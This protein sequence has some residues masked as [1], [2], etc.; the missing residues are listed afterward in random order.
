MINHSPRRLLCLDLKRGIARRYLD[1]KRVEN[2]TVQCGDE[3]TPEFRR[4]LEAFRMYGF[5]GIPQATG[6]EAA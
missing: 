6:P 5:A 2:V 4:E 3:V 1:K